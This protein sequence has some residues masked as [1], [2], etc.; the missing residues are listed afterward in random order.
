MKHGKSVDP[1]VETP[2][3]TV[4]RVLR[5]FMGRG[6]GEIVVF[7]DEAHHCYQNKP[8]S[9]ERRR[10]RAK[11][12]RRGS[13]GPGSSRHENIVSMALPSDVVARLGDRVPRHAALLASLASVV[14]G[15]DQLR[16]LELGCS[17]G[18]GA[19]DED[20]IALNWI[21]SSSPAARREGR[22]DRTLVGI[23][24]RGHLLPTE[25]F[26]APVVH[27]STRVI[28]RPSAEGRNPRAGLRR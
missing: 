1:F 10:P 26:R 23:N 25:G 28:P 19:G 17:L 20:S 11:L 18:P 13:A 9:D 4:A 14:E 6:K 8:L 12:T 7:N 3:E 2:D 16:W 5:D 15:G 27:R 22:P 21:S 24:D